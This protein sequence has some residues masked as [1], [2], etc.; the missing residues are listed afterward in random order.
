MRSRLAVCVLGVWSLL[1]STTSQ[2]QPPGTIAPSRIYAPA[3]YDASN[4]WPAWGVPGYDNYANARVPAS[5]QYGAGPDGLITEQISGD[6]GFDYE[7][8]PV[9]RFLTAAVKSTWIR[10]EYL[11]WRIEGPGKSLLGS[12]V[13]GTVDP[14]QPFQ[15]TISGLPATAQVPTTSALHFRNVQGIRGTMGL[16]TSA[17]TLE[18]NY[19][20]F[21]RATNG[22]FLAVAAPAPLAPQLQIQYATSTLLN[23]QPSNNLFLYDSSFEVVQNSQLFGAEANWI[24]NS[25]YETGFVVRPLAGFRYINVKE[26]LLQLGTFDHEGQ[27]APALVSTINS[28]VDNRIY[29]PQLGMRFE[30][31][32][33][34]FTLG[35]EPKVAFG[36]NQYAATVRTDRLR[37]AG[38]PTVITS[39]NGNHFAPVGDFSVYGKIHLR[40]NFSLFVSYQ[41]MVANG[42]SRPADNIF[43]NDNGSAQPAGIVVDPGFR[44]MVWQGLTVGGELK[45]R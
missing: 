26:G 37:S 3:P 42:I 8:T 5:G 7:D 13:A 38:D 6:R 1:A 11:N 10:L 44:S 18:A 16:P 39:A 12:P 24:A 25:P 17:G 33:Q 30:W 40:D 23:G 20:A 29:A 9:D 19:F 4:S 15:A 14:S 34:W 32:D 43:Y 22:Q 35:I 2:A 45:F 36:V 31:V 21:S 28:N 27:L 41:L